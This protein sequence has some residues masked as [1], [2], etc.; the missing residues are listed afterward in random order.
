MA[1]ALEFN[2]SLLSFPSEEGV[3][4]MDLTDAIPWLEP[5]TDGPVTTGLDILN[6]GS[7]WVLYAISCIS[8]SG[9]HYQF[10]PM[11]QILGPKQHIK[12]KGRICLSIILSR[13]LRLRHCFWH[14]GEACH[15]QGSFT[16]VSTRRHMC[17]NHTPCPRSQ[18]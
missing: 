1:Y 13:F 18:G 11:H 8:P 6:K 3:R 15:K 7:A 5:F 10:F 14:S 9:T 4:T 12:S 17:R 2:P 16:Q